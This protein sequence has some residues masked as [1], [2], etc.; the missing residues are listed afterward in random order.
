MDIVGPFE[1]SSSGNGYILV[2]FGYATRYPEAFPLKSVKARYVTAV[3]QV[4]HT[5]RGPDRLWDTF[6]IWAA[7]TG[8]PAVRS[9]GD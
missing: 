1:G 3:L 6:Y 5:Q 2:F 7:M 4:R 8:L 9:K